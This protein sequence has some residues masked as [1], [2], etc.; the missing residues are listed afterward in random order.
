MKTQNAHAHEDRLLDFA[1]DEL[2]RS[3]ALLVEQHVQGCA[4]C[5]ETLRDIRGVRGTMSHLPRMSAPDTGMESLLAYAQQSARRAAA[6]AEPAPR[7]WRRLLAPALSVA[8]VG[9]LGVVVIQMSAQE[10]PKPSFKQS[11]QEPASRHAYDSASAPASAP[12]RA[13]AAL[14]PA[15]A[16]AP[17]VSDEVGRR[18]EQFD[19]RIRQ[20]Q[21]AEPLAKALPPP[22]PSAS[23]PLF[24]R[25]RGAV[26]AEEAEGSLM[27]SG[28]GF[29]AKKSASNFGQ[30]MR[31]NS[32]PGD[33]TADDA[34]ESAAEAPPMA[35]PS[36]SPAPGAAAPAS[37]SLES[38]E[39]SK[40]DSKADSK[41][42]SKDK[43]EPQWE[44]SRESPAA[45]AS[46]G[47][48]APAVPP[49]VL[50]S[51]AAAA[52]R[53]GDREQEVSLL[54]EALAAGARSVDVFSRLC[55]GEAALGRRQNA[56]EACTRVVRMAPGSSEAERAQRLLDGELHTPGAEAR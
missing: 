41:A 20:E 1:Y 15:P 8:A 5:T 35:K 32:Q 3:E 24:E 28:G 11:T 55:Q 30:V 12:A 42:E 27:G 2:S 10:P 31:K 45:R 51:Q 13:P 43:R 26:D 34:F 14:A 7:W 18:H 22:A 52:A 44:R 19:D 49:S 21:R 40:A 6:G 25:R 33:A 29:P 48:A 54:R 36:P 23:A 46:A 37:P 56:L 47:R 4:R 9:A 39:E 53:E 16:A 17:H 38:Q 50:L